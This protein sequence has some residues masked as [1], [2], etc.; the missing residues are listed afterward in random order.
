MKLKRKKTVRG[1]WVKMLEEDYE[2][3]Q[4]ELYDCEIRSKS[5]SENEIHIK[6]KIQQHVFRNLKQMQSEHSKI[7]D[8]CYQTFKTQ[9]YMK[10]HILNNHEVSLL[11]A[12][13]SNAS[14]YF[15]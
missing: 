15:K 5:K 8:M 13:R 14:K 3:L 2:T 10:T 7:H 6:N 12:L 11:F 9:D 1:D 4:I